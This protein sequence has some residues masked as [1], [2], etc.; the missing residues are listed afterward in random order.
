MSVVQN[1]LQEWSPLETFLAIPVV[2]KVIDSVGSVVSVTEYQRKLDS[3]QA[4]RS[5]VCPVRAS[6]LGRRANGRSA[7]TLRA[8]APENLGGGSGVAAIASNGYIMIA[9]VL[10]GVGDQVVFLVESFIRW[11][12]MS[13]EENYTGTVA[14]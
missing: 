14:R 8:S 7:C 12:L 2:F 6:K 4:Y 9:Q 5:P 1:W 3:S 10:S 13:F 11:N